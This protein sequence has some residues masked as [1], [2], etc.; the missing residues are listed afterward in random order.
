[1]LREPMGKL[2]LKHSL[3]RPEN[4]AFPRSLLPQ[5]ELHK[6]HKEEQQVPADSVKALTFNSFE[7]PGNIQWRR[8]I[9]TDGYKFHPQPQSND[10]LDGSTLCGSSRCSN[11]RNIHNALEIGQKIGTG[12][13]G[14]VFMCRQKGKREIWALKV[15]RSRSSSKEDHDR[16]EYLE[17]VELEKSRELC[18]SGQL[19]PN[20]V[21]QVA[22][23]CHPH[24]DG[25][26]FNMIIHELGTYGDLFNYITVTETGMPEYDARHIFKQLLD[27]LK[28][29]VC[30]N[31]PISL[32]DFIL[33]SQSRRMLILLI[34]RQQH[35]TPGYKSR[36]HLL[37]QPCPSALDQNW[38]SW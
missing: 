31:L 9:V 23:I 7:A 12:G 36:E 33:D 10:G 30:S 3:S 29:L 20:I 21:K 4:S 8:R 26:Q 28:F 25:R 35:R 11:V 24:S 22:Q 2:N 5:K 17:K 32:L 14:S 16:R 13:A 1:M 37:V 6:T 38:R 27:G 18:R 19:P 34:A 15:F